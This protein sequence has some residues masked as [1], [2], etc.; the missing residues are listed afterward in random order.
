MSA[1]KKLIYYPTNDLLR[2]KMARKYN[3]NTTNL[4]CGV[5]GGV[6]KG[7]CFFLLELSIFSSSYK[8]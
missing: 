3:S 8:V 2:R 4:V 7:F 1:P 5:A 6:S